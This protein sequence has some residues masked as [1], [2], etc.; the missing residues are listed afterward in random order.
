MRILFLLLLNCVLLFDLV[1]AKDTPQYPRDKFAD[2]LPEYK[3]LFTPE[4]DN[5]L[6]GIIAKAKGTVTIRLKEYKGSYE[7]RDFKSGEKITHHW[8]YYPL[9]KV[10]KCNVEM[11][12]NMEKDYAGEVKYELNTVFKDENN[13]TPKVTWIYETSDKFSSWPRKS[14]MSVREYLDFAGINTLIAEKTGKGTLDW[15]FDHHFSKRIDFSESI[16]LKKLAD[17]YDDKSKTDPYDIRD[18]ENGYD[19]EPVYVDFASN[20]LRNMLQNKFHFKINDNTAKWSVQELKWM[21]ELLSN[22][23]GVPQILD[24]FGDTKDDPIRSINRD[25]KADGLV[26]KERTVA[27]YNEGEGNISVSNL[28]KKSLYNYNDEQYFKWVIL[29]EITHALQRKYMITTPVTKNK[30]SNLTASYARATNYNMVCDET[31]G[32]TS[33]VTDTR[34]VYSRY[35]NGSKDEYVIKIFKGN[36]K[37]LESRYKKEDIKDLDYCIRQGKLWDFWYKGFGDIGDDERVTQYAK[38]NIIEDMAESVGIYYIHPL[39]L[40]KI[41]P[42]RYKWIWKNVFQG[43]EFYMAPFEGSGKVSVSV[44]QISLNGV[45]PTRDADYEFSFKGRIKESLIEKE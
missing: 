6:N 17:P 32:W 44:K 40:K 25:E 8:R 35:M 20:I 27:G 19:K 9:K 14:E 23:S 16:S 30:V 42:Q 18:E 21:A 11:K 1:Y 29:H 34:T 12:I 2:S 7:G 24:L 10:I 39:F 5:N 13:K 26:D 37:H 45:P 31:S 4:N 38:T 36:F 41:S 43:K 15:K 28:V 3:R 33:P 22:L